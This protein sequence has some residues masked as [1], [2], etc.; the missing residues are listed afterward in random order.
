M[1]ARHKKY[2]IITA[3]DPFWRGLLGLI[4][5]KVT[6]SKLQVQVHTDFASETRGTVLRQAL[7]IFV[8]SRADGVRV[9][10]ERVRV[11]VSM[12]TRALISVLPVYIDIE[13]IRE[14]E[15]LDRLQQ[16]PQFRKLVLVVARL[17]PEKQVSAAIESFS[18]IS[19]EVPAV[20]L[21]I[22]GQG[23]MRAKLEVLAQE[24][25][26]TSQVVFLGYRTDVGALYKTADVLLMTSAFESYGASIIEAL[27]AGCPVVAP[28]V[29]VAREAGASVVA[30][31]DLASRVVEVLQNGTKGE[32]QLPV[33]SRDEWVATWRRGLE[34]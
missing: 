19:K 32:L 21:L 15:P 10:S 14:S 13:K 5:S 7:G 17:E 4:L 22:V 16:F 23:S 24:L 2:D 12:Y 1:A 6:G 18:K 29:G 26:L 30:R 25:G 28:D 34:L 8:L 11:S 31:E 27:A 3:Q 9:V 20:G 33:L